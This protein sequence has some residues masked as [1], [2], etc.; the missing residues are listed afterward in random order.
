MFCSWFPR[1]R[2]QPRFRCATSGQSQVRLSDQLWDLKAR[3]GLALG[4][5]TKNWEQYQ[6]EMYYLNT[7]LYN[8]SHLSVIL[9]CS[10]PLFGVSKPYSTDSNKTSILLVFFLT[11][12][13]C[14][15]WMQKLPGPLMLQVTGRQ[16]H[17]GK[18]YFRG[19]FMCKN[20]ARWLKALYSSSL[21]PWL[22]SSLTA[23]SVAAP[24]TFASIVEEELQQEA[25]LI[26][27]REKPLALIQVSN[28]PFWV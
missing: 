12:S 8:L 17:T 18:E 22:S 23:P 2:R 11:L 27:S 5:H 19:D 28:I 15:V 6:I 14:W 7:L 25:A 24:V 26:R 3:L 1:T 20:L 4:E 10:I 13:F 9:L 21:S 16:C